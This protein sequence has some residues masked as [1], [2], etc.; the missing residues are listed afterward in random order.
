MLSN[1]NNIHNMKNLSFRTTSYSIL[2]IILSIIC[3]LI[4]PI[5]L[6]PIF[7]ASAA[8]A[9]GLLLFNFLKIFDTIEDNSAIKYWEIKQDDDSNKR[10]KKLGNFL[11][12]YCSLLYSNFLISSISIFLLY[13]FN[14]D[15]AFLLLTSTTIV[16]LIRILTYI[17][18]GIAREIG[19]GLGYAMLPLG[20]ALFIWDFFGPLINNDPFHPFQAIYT[21]I[22]T[23]VPMT[24]ALI[25]TLVLITSFEPLFDL[26]VNKINR[27]FK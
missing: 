7:Y 27:Y 16:I 18:R 2:I 1:F 11:Y 3:Y 24:L 13:K 19:K 25:L 15:V 17:N 10:I 21:F 5:A 9:I 6:L 23:K 26:L 4:R 8:F 14:N 22:I 20:F 12:S